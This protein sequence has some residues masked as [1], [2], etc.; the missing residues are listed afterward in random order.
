[1]QLLLWFLKWTSETA[2]TDLK[3]LWFQAKNQKMIKGL[4]HLT[5][6]ERRRELGL[7]CLEKRRFWDGSGFVN[8][9]NYLMGSGK[10]DVARLFSVVPNER[11]RGK[12]HSFQELRFKLRKKMLF[13]LFNTGAGCLGRL[14][15][16]SP[17]RYSEANWTWSWEKCC[18]RPSS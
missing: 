17:W 7:L 14:W 9:C 1:M 16:L 5:Y 4:V 10:E 12:G 2:G 6:R 13:E 15:S 3:F 18:S 11:T 8:V